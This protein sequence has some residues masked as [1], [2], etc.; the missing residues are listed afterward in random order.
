MGQIWP[1]A[2]LSGL[3]STFPTEKSISLI[4]NVTLVQILSVTIC[5]ML[6]LV[7]SHDSDLSTSVVSPSVR[8]SVC[9]SVIKTQNHH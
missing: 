8:P 7:F 2:L 1:Y 5:E 6:V 4:L 3:L 9:L